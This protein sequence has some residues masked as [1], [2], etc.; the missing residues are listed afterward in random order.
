MDGYYLER[1]FFEKFQ[2]FKK[3]FESWKAKQKMKFFISP[4]KPS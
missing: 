2:F 1:M 3:A 4:P